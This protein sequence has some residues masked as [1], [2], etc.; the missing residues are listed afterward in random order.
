M[1][2]LYT[3]KLVKLTTESAQN[4]LIPKIWIFISN[5]KFKFESKNK[6]S[7]INFTLQLANFG[8]TPALS[9][10]IHFS[11]PSIVSEE[12]G[13]ETVRYFKSGFPNLI[14]SNKQ[15]EEDL[16]FT[17]D[18]TPEDIEKFKNSF[19][20][21]IIEFEDINRNLHYIRQL[22][23]LNV[24]SGNLIKNVGFTF[25]IILLDEHYYLPKHKQK[26]FHDKPSDHEYTGEQVTFV[27]RKTNRWFR[28]G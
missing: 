22:Y 12:R 15:I 4:D 6:N 13:V 28:F 18:L 14:E 17:I 27:Y 26:Y 7:K 16:E 9:F 20:E 25:W 3:K 11:M 2:V 19:L 24:H 8:K 1:Y 5:P 21:I 23:D 10:S